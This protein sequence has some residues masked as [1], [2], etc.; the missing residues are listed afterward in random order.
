MRRKIEP[1]ANGP[2]V[3]RTHEAM[4]TTKWSGEL[5]WISKAMRPFAELCSGRES[6]AFVC[7]LTLCHMDAVLGANADA[8]R[9]W[10]RDV[11]AELARRGVDAF[12]YEH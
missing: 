8:Q 2:R 10:D 11:A 5:A 4:R 9:F 6:H 3:E 12:V 1:E 7:G